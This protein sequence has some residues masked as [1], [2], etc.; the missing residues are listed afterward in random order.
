[1]SGHPWQTCTCDMGMLGFQRFATWHLP[2]TVP[3]PHIR[4]PP[5]LCLCLCFCFFMLATQP[6]FL[7]PCSLTSPCS[8]H[9]RHMAHAAAFQACH[10]NHLHI[11]YLNHL[12]I[13]SILY[14]CVAVL[15]WYNSYDGNRQGLFFF[16][17]LLW[18]SWFLLRLDRTSA[19]LRRGAIQLSLVLC[20]GGFSKG[21][22]PIFDKRWHSSACI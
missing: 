22:Q 3:L 10:L 7:G 9:P 12:C 5:N 4:Y 8:W 18:I 2:A 21:L 19:W 6:L 11:Q 16:G 17:Y 20:C 14:W 13:S 15:T 1:M